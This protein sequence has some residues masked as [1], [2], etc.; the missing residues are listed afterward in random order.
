[1]QYEIT[2]TI[3]TPKGVYKSYLDNLVNTFAIHWIEYH[4]QRY[5]WRCNGVDI[6]KQDSRGVISINLLEGSRHVSQSFHGKT[7]R[8]YIAFMSGFTEDKQ[9]HSIK[10]SG[11]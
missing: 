10:E 8:D 6:S 7:A 9:W 2:H 11:Q 3:R 5:G 1:M 4:N